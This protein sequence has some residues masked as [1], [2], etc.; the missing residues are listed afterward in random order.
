VLTWNLAPSFNDAA[1]T[2]DPPPGAHPIVLEDL[3]ADSAG[4]K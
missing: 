2:F 1:F 3:S 4:K